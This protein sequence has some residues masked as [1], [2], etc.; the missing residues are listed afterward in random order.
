MQERKKKLVRE[1]QMLLPSKK[2]LEQAGD[3]PQDPAW[4]RPCAGVTLPPLSLDP[5]HQSVE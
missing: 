1:Q 3:A 2:E 4:G 5:L